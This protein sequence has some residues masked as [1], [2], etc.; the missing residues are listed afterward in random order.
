MTALRSLDRLARILESRVVAEQ[1]RRRPGLQRLIA[2]AGGLT[3]AAAAFFL[4]KGAAI[5]AGVAMPDGTGLALWIAGADPVA[6]AF[7]A[8]LQPVF[9][10]RG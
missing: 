3:L 5:A 4:L 1:A 2:M 7:G 10:G 8:T 6:Q 9:A